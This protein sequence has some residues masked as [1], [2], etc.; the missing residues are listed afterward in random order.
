VP[1]EDWSPQFQELYNETPGIADV[2]P[3]EES[4]VE[5]L[6]DA[7]FTHHGDEYEASGLT[8]D[9]VHAIREEFFEYMGLAEE[10]FD[11]ED[12]REAMGYGND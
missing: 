7:G 10:N 5:A 1:Y 4:H 8:E 12:W 11:W 9:D 2:E 3:W 6:F